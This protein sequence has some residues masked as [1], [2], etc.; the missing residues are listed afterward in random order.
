MRIAQLILERYEHGAVLFECDNLDD[1]QR[2]IGGFGSTGVAS[3]MNK[4]DVNKKDTKTKD[5]VNFDE[6]KKKE[7]D[8]ENINEN[9][10]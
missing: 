1:T 7:T 4:L 2:G 9:V 6:S 5:N 8:K 3:M 10:V